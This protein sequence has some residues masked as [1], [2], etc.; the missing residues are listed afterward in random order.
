MT[1]IFIDND[2]QEYDY[3]TLYS[4]RGYTNTPS[5]MLVVYDN[6]MV[7]LEGWSNTGFNWIEQ[8][9]QWYPNDETPYYV[10]QSSS[11]SLYKI[12]KKTNFKTYLNN[13]EPFIIYNN[14]F[15]T[16]ENLHNTLGYTQT[17]S[18][19]W[20]IDEGVP[21]SWYNSDNEEYWNNKT[22]E[23]TSTPPKEEDDE[24]PPILPN[25]MPLVEVDYS[26]DFEEPIIL[27][28]LTTYVEHYPV[29]EWELGDLLKPV[30]SDFTSEDLISVWKDDLS[31]NVPL[32]IVNTDGKDF[33]GVHYDYGDSI[34]ADI[35]TVMVDSQGEQTFYKDLDTYVFPYLYDSLSVS[36]KHYWVE[37]DERYY[38]ESELYDLNYNIYPNNR[39]FV[40]D[41]PVDITT[42]YSALYNAIRGYFY[43]DIWYATEAD[44]NNAGY[45]LIEK[46]TQTVYADTSPSGSSIN[47]YCNQSIT[48]NSTSFN[49][50]STSYVKSLYLDSSLS[51]PYLW[52]GYPWELDLELTTVNLGS[53]VVTKLS[54][55]P[56]STTTSTSSFT[57]LYSVITASGNPI[58]PLVQSELGTQLKIYKGCNYSSSTYISYSSNIK[59]VLSFWRLYV[60]QNCTISFVNTDYP[61]FN[62]DLPNS[63]TA[64]NGSS[65][66]LPTISGSFTE[67][68]VTYEPYRWNIG[69]FGDTYLLLDNVTA[70]LQFRVVF[71]EIT[72]YMA[73]GSKT[74]QRGVTSSFTGDVNTYGSF[75][76]DLFLDPELTQPFVYDYSNDYEVGHVVNGQWVRYID[77][78]SGLPDHIEQEGHSQYVKVAYILLD[79][80][81]LWICCNYVTGFSFSVDVSSVVVRIYPKDNR[82]DYHVGYFNT[83]NIY[84]NVTDNYTGWPVYIQPGV[85]GTSNLMTYINGSEIVGVYGSAGNAITL[86]SGDYLAK[87]SQ[88][89]PWYTIRFTPSPQRTLT[90]RHIVF[91]TLRS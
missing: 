39:V 59:L 13:N 48:K 55:M 51:S 21:W 15:T 66:V 63:I 60:V 73:S 62:V 16:V 42:I 3:D 26:Y 65:V 68:G 54:S 70:V 20:D 57:T 45:Y 41:D 30:D 88:A 85:S 81:K 31:L 83:S 38:T 75:S 37:S 22:H 33:Q 64:N 53:T 91:R 56:S 72:L 23:W 86:E 71:S 50:T 90:I 17:P 47:W 27:G 84:G 11:I 77:S 18:T 6:S 76:Y 61:Q 32:Y 80:G 29:K 46:V 69:E 35:F 19:V 28:G 79:L 7:Q 5:T 14:S 49:T 44:L 9:H 40:T 8:D 67:N 34:L 25:P 4:E 43:N 89:P 10:Q 52:N 36:L 24:E 58:T 12:D 2:W 74:T 82:Y 87:Y 78:V 1:K